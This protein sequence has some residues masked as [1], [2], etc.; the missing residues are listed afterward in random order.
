MENKVDNVEIR[1][2]NGVEFIIESMSS[3]NY[4]GEW[5]PSGYVVRWEDRH[6]ILQ[7]YSFI[8][9]PVNSDLQK[10]LDIL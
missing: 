3:F 7:E 8:G 9:Y 2:V 1:W 4:N 10:L 5:E 6:N